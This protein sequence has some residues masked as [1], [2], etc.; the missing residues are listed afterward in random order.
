[1]I[2]SRFLFSSRLFTCSLLSR[3]IVFWGGVGVKDEKSG[4]KKMEIELSW[5]LN[6]CEKKNASF[7]IINGEN[8]FHCHSENQFRF[9]FCTLIGCRPR[10]AQIGK[11][12]QQL[13]IMFGSTFEAKLMAAQVAR[14]LNRIKCLS[15]RLSVFTPLKGCPFYLTA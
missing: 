1:M 8:L 4:T 6:F 12:T 7:E 15:S 14:E 5:K 2:N 3:W 9:C 10:L 13:R 11:Y